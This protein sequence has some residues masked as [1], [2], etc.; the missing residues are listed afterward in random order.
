MWSRGLPRAY[1]V[2]LEQ[3]AGPPGS[4]VLPGAFL[5]FIVV[6]AASAALALALGGALEAG[7]FLLM[8]T[9]HIYRPA[10]AQMVAEGGISQN[11]SQPR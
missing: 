8:N 9:D 11:S 3:L 4:V 10:I 7:G 6:V 1:R 5:R 2:P